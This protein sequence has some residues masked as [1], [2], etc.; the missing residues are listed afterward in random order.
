MAYRYKERLICYLLGGFTVIFFKVTSGW[1]RLGALVNIW[2]VKTLG[3][4]R[5]LLHL[6]VNLTILHSVVL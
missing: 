5:N 2:T 4:Y 6:L 3:P 1:E